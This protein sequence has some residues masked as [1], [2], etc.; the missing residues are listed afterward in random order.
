MSDVIDQIFEV[1][2][3]AEFLRE[4]ATILVN[5]HELTSLTVVVQEGWQLGSKIAQLRKEPDLGEITPETLTKLLHYQATLVEET[6]KNHAQNLALIN[7]LTRLSLNLSRMVREI[8]FIEDA[9]FRDELII[10]KRTGVLIDE[11]TLN[12]AVR[13]IATLFSKLG[14]IQPNE[15]PTCPLSALLVQLARILG[16]IERSLQVNVVYRGSPQILLALTKL[17]EDFQQNFRPIYWNVKQKYFQ[18]EIATNLAALESLTLSVNARE[19]QPIKA[20]KSKKQKE[21][22]EILRSLENIF[23]K[24]SQR[25]QMPPEDAP[26]PELK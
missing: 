15:T 25:K 19:E 9:E 16:M 23:N 20:K 14:E 4:D 22:A 6:S 26:L 12:Q 24:E 18:D 2:K 7:H 21:L 11:A 8:P 10:K 1:S 17:G 13:E 5:A 3:L